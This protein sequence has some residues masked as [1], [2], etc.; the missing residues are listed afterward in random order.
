MGQD[1]PFVSVIVLNYN[2]LRFLDD[3]FQSLEKI[4]YPNFEVVMVDNRSTD[5][6]VKYVKENY[7]WIRVIEAPENNGFAYGNNIGIR[8]TK[9]KYV[10]LLNN[11]TI[12]TPDFLTRV[13]EEAELDPTIGIAGSWPLDYKYRQ[14]KDDAL[15]FYAHLRHKTAQ[16][17][18]VAGAVMLIRRDAL[19]KIGLLDKKYFLYWEDA[20][21]CWRATLMGYKVVMVYDS[22]VYHLVNAT[23][24]PTKKRWMYE[25]V[26]NKIYTHIKLMN[27]RNLCLF[28]CSEILRSI[29]RMLRNP[30]LATSVLK[31]WWWN[32]RNLKISLMER[33]KIRSAK[34]IR[35]K[36]LIE[37][38]RRD[39]KLNKRDLKKLSELAEKDRKI[40]NTL[41]TQKDK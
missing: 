24:L 38:I 33:K 30:V 25:F 35:D 7:G 2:G 28:L 8:N 22:F 23:G 10:Y 31:G 9:G 1:Y 4:D 40:M 39:D 17:S 11:D 13:V 14:Y 3:C 18:A 41:D 34:K 37:L 19:D 15:R 16:V 6:S 21:F 5:G 36:D 27:W 32:L 29:G 26:K 20:E 12:C